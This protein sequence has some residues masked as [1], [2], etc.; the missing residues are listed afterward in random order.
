MVSSE[1]EVLAVPRK[2]VTWTLP[3][4]QFNPAEPEPCASPP[5]TCRPLMTTCSSTAKNSRPRAKVLALHQP[6]A[7]QMYRDVLCATSG[8]P[9]G[10]CGD[11]DRDFV[12]RNIHFFTSACDQQ[13]TGPCP[14]RILG[15]YSKI[16]FASTGHGGEH[17]FLPIPAFKHSYGIS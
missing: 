8:R 1:G 16:S 11:R 5:C 2:A 7:V 15:L 9:A 4:N 10:R 6:A 3:W 12:I 17:E 13:S 14:G